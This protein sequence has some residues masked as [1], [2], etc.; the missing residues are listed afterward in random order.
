MKYK[1]IGKTLLINGTLVIG[2]VHLGYEESLNQSGVLI[3]RHQFE[4]TIRDIKK[5]FE[6]LEN[7]EKINEIVILGDL[8]H[9]FSRVSEQEWNDVFRFLEYLLAK[10]GKIVVVKG[11]HDTMLAP[12]LAKFPA[13]NFVGQYIAGE[14]AFVHG[15]EEIKFGKEVKTIVKGD[16]H[17]AITI[18]EGAKHETFKCF[19]VGKS[20]GQ[21][22]IILPSFLPIVEGTDVREYFEFSNYE[23]FIVGDEVYDFGKVKN[24]K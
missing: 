9:E 3:P 15:D 16:L 8:K 14:V 24:I 5:I 19:L 13:I 10:C 23:V 17:P 21:E 20:G 6:K 2:D 22:I 11:Q 7:K 18:R 1:F 12:I 4:E